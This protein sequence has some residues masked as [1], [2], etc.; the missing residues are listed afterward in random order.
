MTIV[1]CKVIC[2]KQ[3]PVFVEDLL[4]QSLSSNNDACLWRL[5]HEQCRIVTPYNHYKLGS[6]ETEI[7]KTLFMVWSNSRLVAFQL[8]RDNWYT[9]RTTNT[10]CG[11]H[12]KYYKEGSHMKPTGKRKK[13]PAEEH[14]ATRSRRWFQDVWS[15]L[16]RVGKNGTR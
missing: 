4:M 7:L 6:S 12:R 10:P 5:P 2:L 11:S 3:I 8:H 13:E 14:V 1:T 15:H 16:G 9:V